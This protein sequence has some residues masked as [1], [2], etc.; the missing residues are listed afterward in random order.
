VWEPA[1][2]QVLF[3]PF[4]V[5]RAIKFRVYRFTIYTNARTEERIVVEIGV[6]KGV[7]SFA[8]APPLALA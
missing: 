5:Y 1:F 6:F 8:L 3:E 7:G 4:A 2:F